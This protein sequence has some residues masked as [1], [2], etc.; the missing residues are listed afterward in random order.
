MATVYKIHPAIGIARV[1]NSPDEFFI[2]PERVGEIPDPPGGFKDSQCRVR[3]QAARFHIFAHHDDGSVEEITDASADITWTVHLVNS[4]AAHPNRGNAPAGDLVIDPGSRTLTGPDQQQLFDSGSIRFAGQQAVA[5]PLGE[6]RTDDSN[7]LLVLGGSG[8]AASPA[9]NQIGDFWGNVGWYDDVSDGPVRATLTLRADGSTPAVEQAW[10]IVTPP[11]FAPHQ[12]SPTTLYDRMAQEM[13]DRGL[14]AAPTTTSYTADVYP[15]LQRARD[16]RWV[17]GIFGAHTWPDPVTDQ[18]LVDAIF[19]RLRPP[20][21]MPALNG[22]DS[23]LT[24][25][26]YAHMERWKNGN[27]AADWVGTPVPQAAITPDGLDRAALEACVG[28]AFFP[29]IEA[30]GLDDGDRPILES[31]YAAP[32]R[33]AAS[34]TAGSIGAAMALPWQADFKACGDNWW[35]VPRPND[36]ISQNTG[37]QVRWER[38]VSSM[39]DMVTLWNTLGFVVRQGE[40]HV[41]VQHCDES[42]VALLTPHLDFVDVPQGP[43]GMVRETVLAISF[44]VISP[45]SAVT[46]EYAPGGAP[47]HPQLVAIAT[48]VTVGPTAPNA[49]ATARLWIVYRTGV[50]P[51]AIPTQTVTVREPASEQTWQVTIDGN[52]VAPSTTG[53][54]LVLDR[55]GSMSGDRGDGQSKHNAMQQAAN[56]FVDLMLPDDGVGIVRF[57]E[58]AQQLQPLLVLGNGGISDV[59]RGATHDVINGASLVPQGATSIGDGIFEGR[60]LLTAPAFD[61]S[62]LVVLTDGIENSPR[63][64]AEVA[65]QINERTYAIGLGMPQNISVPALQTISGNN[66]GY[67][68]VTGAITGD[69]RFQLQKYF[70]QILAGINNA[71]VVLDPDGTLGRGEVHRIPFQLCDGDSGVDVV[72]LTAKPEGVDFRLQTPNGLLIEPWRARLEQSMR[73]EMG[74]GVAYYRLALPAQLRPGR[75][76]RSGTWHVLLTLGRPRVDRQDDNDE[77]VDLSIL[78]GRPGPSDRPVPRR[79]PAERERAFAVHQAQEGGLMPAAA[80]AGEP[81]QGRVGLP[82]SVVV[83]A[84]SSITLRARASQRSFEPG[85]EVHLHAVLA[86]SGLPV[87]GEPAVWADIT[88]PDGTNWTQALDPDGLGGFG[89]QFVASVPGLYRARVRARGRTRTGR[90]FVR[91]ATV[92]AAAYRGAD[93]PPPSGD[94][95][96]DHSLCS[97]LACLLKP[98]GMIDEGLEKRLRELGIDLDHARRCLRSCRSQVADE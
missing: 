19:A 75:F 51:S 5:V 12:D 15:I 93:N 22:I 2:G 83:H 8:S 48:S 9:N 72:L 71:E 44:E 59:N 45:S 23:V 16:M 11:K 91:E 28:G 27:Y 62:A 57:N 56:I 36:V 88:G 33:L 67:L 20:G 79:R 89:T 10:V 38:D 7:H 1:G 66:G 76:D 50:A 47:N 84:Y 21:D 81:P 87:G 14:L 97:L 77:G 95:G 17:E 35:P 34:V 31:A 82:Y 58:D 41:E 32:F 78:R 70:V 52:T 6:M 92:T 68:L 73:F 40:E 29:G 86:Q 37:S 13:I 49:V 55:S 18:V 26:Q 74:D 80:A 54:A 63:Y 98:D 90:P 65:G 46:L 4:K 94:G 69:N 25:T 43:M 53:T 61:N 60:A 3:R 85:A 42:S 24:T 64:I 30:G 39:G 96:H